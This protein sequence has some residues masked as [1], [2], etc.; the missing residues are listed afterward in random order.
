[1]K[2]GIISAGQLGS[3]YAKRWAK[4]GHQVILTNCGDLSKLNPLLAEIGANTSAAPAHEA[5][6]QAA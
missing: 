4:A 5:V 2:I 3:A 1:M 6:A